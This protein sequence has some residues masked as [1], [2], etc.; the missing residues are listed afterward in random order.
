MPLPASLNDMG[1]ILARW[2]L[3]LKYD[4]ASGELWW[5]YVVE[6][7]R[8]DSLVPAQ[9]VAA[10]RSITGNKARKMVRID[11][12]T[13]EAAKLVWLLHHNAW[14]ERRL[15]RQDGDYLNDRIEN[16]ALSKGAA[17]PERKRPPGVAKYYDRWQAYARLPDGRNKNLGV[18]RTQEAAMAARKAWDDANDLV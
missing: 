8:F 5:R 6:T 16:L 2:P 3:M 14:P 7:H 10:Y 17:G 15:V 4:G 13:V 18:F 11:G 1:P 12:Y 9:Y